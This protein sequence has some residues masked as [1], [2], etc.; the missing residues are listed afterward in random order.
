MSRSLKVG[1]PFLGALSITSAASIPA[2]DVSTI[3]VPTAYSKKE[4]VKGLKVRSV[5]P[6]SQSTVADIHER[7]SKFEAMGA[8]GAASRSPGKSPQKKRLKI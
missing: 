8:A 3:T 7:K 6:G 1:D 2:L 4:Q 5:P